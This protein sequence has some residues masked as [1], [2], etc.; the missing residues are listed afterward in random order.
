MIENVGVYILGFIHGEG[1]YFWWSW[2]Y[3]DV[4][5]VF[6]DFVGIIDVVG[7]FSWGVSL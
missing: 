4:Y 7:G 6:L 1:S 3:G 5:Y 2:E